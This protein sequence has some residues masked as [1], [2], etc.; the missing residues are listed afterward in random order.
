MLESW[1]GSSHMTWLWYVRTCVYTASVLPS[2]K[3]RFR[4]VALELVLTCGSFDCL[5]AR[6]TQVVLL[7]VVLIVLTQ[8]LSGTTF[9]ELNAWTWTR[10]V[11]PAKELLQFGSA[12]DCYTVIPKGSNESCPA[13]GTQTSCSSPLLCLCL[14]ILSQPA[15]ASMRY[16]WCHETGL[17]ANTR[18]QQT[19]NR[20]ATLH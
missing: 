2:R 13:L 18:S 20:F 1:C 11:A 3:D 8:T 7:C 17:P 9:F 6:L 10:F 19:D 5:S 14:R 16:C 12:C 15:N 4:A